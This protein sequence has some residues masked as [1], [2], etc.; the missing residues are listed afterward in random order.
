MLA[1]KYTCI[2]LVIRDFS[3]F[4]VLDN[5]QHCPS[6]APCD[7][8]KVWSRARIILKQSGGRGESGK[9]SGQTARGIFL[10]SS[11]RSGRTGVARR[12]VNWTLIVAAWI[13]SIEASYRLK[14]QKKKRQKEK[15][16]PGKVNCGG[17]VAM[18]T[19]LV[20]YCSCLKGER[21]G[22]CG[23]GGAR[24]VWRQDEG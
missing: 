15:E 22:G 9:W 4:L 11:F 1:F 16:K 17:A 6:S 13:A 7:H 5:R 24:E 14:E 21:G 18:V 8:L 2:Y 3:K 23:V 19:A 20:H 12:E 10:P